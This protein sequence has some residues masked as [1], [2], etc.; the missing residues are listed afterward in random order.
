[1]E[2]PPLS[3]DAKTFFAAAR[4]LLASVRASISYQAFPMLAAIHA[5]FGIRKYEKREAILPVGRR[6]FTPEAR[7]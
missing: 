2:R 1:M 3:P 6:I 4:F 7:V 5:L